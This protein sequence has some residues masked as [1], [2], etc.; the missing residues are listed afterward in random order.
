MILKDQIVLLPFASLSICIIGLI[1]LTLFVSQLGFTDK[2]MLCG[3][4]PYMYFKNKALDL[5]WQYTED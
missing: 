2:K 5:Y 3:L 4:G 1:L